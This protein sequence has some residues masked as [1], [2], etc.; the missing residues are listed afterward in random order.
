MTADEGDD[1]YGQY[2]R[3]K[4]PLDGHRPFH[5]EGIDTQLSEARCCVV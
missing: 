5:H 2:H 3:A 4:L 1:E